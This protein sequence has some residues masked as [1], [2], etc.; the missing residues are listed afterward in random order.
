MP[1]ASPQAQKGLLGAVAPKGRKGYFKKRVW[2]AGLASVFPNYNHRGVCII[3]FLE[4][5]GV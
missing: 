3:A 5:T 1:C 2:K 4:R